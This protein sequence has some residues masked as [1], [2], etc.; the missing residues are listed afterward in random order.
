MYSLSLTLPISLCAPSS[1]GPN[2]HY[3]WQSKAVRSNRPSL[4]YGKLQKQVSMSSDSPSPSLKIIGWY[5]ATQQKQEH[6][7]HFLNMKYLWS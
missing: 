4:Q 7:T 1:S 6:A 3:E 5:R 2:G